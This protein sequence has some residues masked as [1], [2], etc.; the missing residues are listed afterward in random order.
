MIKG[1]ECMRGAGRK[2]ISFVVMVSLIVTTTV[3]WAATPTVEIVAM[4][5]P[6]VQSVLKPLRDWLAQQGK[7]IRVIE[8]DA[9]SPQGKSRL[10]AI[11]LKGHIPIAIMI[12]NKTS[13]RRANGDSVS[14]VNFPAVKESPS[15]VRGNWQIQDVQAALLEQISKQ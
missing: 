3:A 11:E 6:P 1:Y 2:I 8:V 15:G 4:A 7:K 5:H 10:E 12:N 14:F 13:Y 9:E